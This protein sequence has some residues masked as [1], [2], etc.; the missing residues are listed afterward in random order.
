MLTI[1]SLFSGIGGLDLGLERAGLGPVLWQVEKDEFC[2][3][4][5]AGHWPNAKRFEDI[6]EV[7]SELEAVDIICGGFPCQPVSVAGRRKAQ[8]DDRWLW[9]EFARIVSVKKPRLVVFENVPG[10]RSAGLRS[11]LADLASLGFDVE[12]A[13]VAASDLG[14]PHQR[15]R[16]FA[17][18][19]DTM[20][21]GV[22]QQPGWLCRAFESAR[23]PVDRPFAEA[24]IAS[25]PDGLRRLESARI[26]AE[27]RGWSRKCG[28]SLGEI[29][30]VDDGLSGTL[31]K[32]RK[33]LGNAVVVQAAEVVGRAITHILGDNP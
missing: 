3:S 25:D 28:W 8:Q 13:C 14:A 20:R 5:L 12:W 15:R 29:A 11:V 27:Q 19:S 4:V 7:G 21:L 6:K 18:A 16:I 26:F 9:P 30:R 31:G 33:A 17:V 32:A 22:R 23:A 2:R 1:G 24:I 10:L